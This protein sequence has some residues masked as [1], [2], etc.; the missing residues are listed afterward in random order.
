[1][2]NFNYLSWDLIEIGITL[3]FARIHIPSSGLGIPA[4][5]L[6]KNLSEDHRCFD[7]AISQQL[8]TIRASISSLRHSVNQKILPYEVNPFVETKTILNQRTK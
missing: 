8:K 6:M 2:R 7:I 1:V 3:F 4:D 5:P